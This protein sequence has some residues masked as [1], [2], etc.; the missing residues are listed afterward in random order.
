MGSDDLS[1][2]TTRTETDSLASGNF[3]SAWARGPDWAT[4]VK[5]CADQLKELPEGAN[6]GFLY[7]TD[8]F[9]KDAS[10]LLTFLRE[11]TGI[12]NWVG[13]VGLGVLSNG[14]EIHDRGAI[15]VMVMALPADSFRIFSSIVDETPD[16]GLAE[17]LAVQQQWLGDQRPGIALVHGDPRNVRLTEIIEA[18]ADAT[19]PF[20]VGG[21]AA[22]RIGEFPQ[23][24]DKVLDGGVS[25]V[26]L[27]PEVEVVTGL[28]QG[29]SP[30]GPLREIT[31]AEG[32]VIRE[33]DGRPAFEVF[34]EDIGELLARDLRRIAGYIF[35]AF[36]MSNSDTS[37][38]LVRNLMSLDAESGQVTVG[39]AVEPGRKLL[40][41]R[42]D[43]A[44]AE[45]D[46]RRMLKDIKARGGAEAQAGLYYSCV[47]RGQNL[48]GSESEEMK[49][50]Q[51]E[52]GDIPIAGFFANGEISRD[53][54]YGYTG[55]L[56]LFR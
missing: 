29:C 51:E 46:M 12:Q 39:E 22:S 50:I 37:D 25:G 53:R 32:N 14:I 54:V 21:L 20:L 23:I 17:L 27:R 56:T 55:V 28:T 34:E 24:A 3:K 45:Q 15:S 35:A 8:A 41:C 43:H 33:I 30:I 6:L 19:A 9:T 48:F 26:L 18:L 42:R 16:K 49:M 7:L 36:P 4:A 40:F 2:N 10:S 31:Q 38:Y 1:Q 13:T 52:L 5:A 11:K 44:A 47:G